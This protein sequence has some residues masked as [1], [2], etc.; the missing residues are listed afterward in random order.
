M[1]KNK[2]PSIFS[3]QI[4]SLLHCV[5]GLF[6]LY[7]PSNIFRKTRDFENSLGYYQVLAGDY[8]VM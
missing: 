6:C 3:R 5:R 2:R 1:S 7:Y 8:S 4:W